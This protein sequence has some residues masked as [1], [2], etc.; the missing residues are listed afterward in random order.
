MGRATQADHPAGPTGQRA[1]STRAAT[2]FGAVGLVWVGAHA[3]GA[4]GPLTDL[5]FVLLAV[6]ALVTSAIGTGW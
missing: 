1:A 4:L 3:I 2:L 5:T 6:A